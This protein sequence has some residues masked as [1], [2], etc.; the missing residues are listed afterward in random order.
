MP[1]DRGL[2]WA[3]GEVEDIREKTGIEN[4][5]QKSD[6]HMKGKSIGILE[7]STMF[8]CFFLNE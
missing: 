8:L 4:N 6:K 3:T 7:D 1:M 2:R 5:I